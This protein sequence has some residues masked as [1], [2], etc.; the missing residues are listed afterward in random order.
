M[1]LSLFKHEMKSNSKLLALFLTIITLYGSIIT[2]MYDPKLGES[3]N[4]LAQSM[5]ELFAAFGMKD[6]GST[7][8]SFLANYLYG[9]ILILIPFIFSLILAYK[10]IG[11]YLANG[12]FAYLLNSNVSRKEIFFTQLLTASLN[13]LVLLLYTIGIVIIISEL[14]FPGDL[15]IGRF[16][17][18]NGCLLILQYFFLSVCFFCAISWDDAKYSMGV[19]SIV[20]FGSILIQM[21]S[22]I[23]SNT[24]FLE[25]FTPLTLFK[26]FDIINGQSESY[27]LIGVLGIITLVIIVISPIRF[28]RR[29]LFL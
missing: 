13:I 9:F 24:T 27:L 2:L 21:L 3:M 20:G 17:I 16:I 18:L 4:S 1:N 5:P 22:Q 26:P 23:N 10:L 29:N 6:P 14:K 11:K 15:D 12:S 7:M 19:A 25:Y 8:I 28:K